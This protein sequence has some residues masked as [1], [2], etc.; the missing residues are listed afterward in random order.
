[1]KTV[2]EL[3]Q[4]FGTVKAKQTGRAIKRPLILEIRGGVSEIELAACRDL[5]FSLAELQ[6]ARRLLDDIEDWLR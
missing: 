6:D 4:A 5:G 2:A 3:R 1:M